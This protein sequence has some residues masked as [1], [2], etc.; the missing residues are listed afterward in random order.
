MTHNKQKLMTKRESQTKFIFYIYFIRHKFQNFCLFCVLLIS[1]RPKVI[2]ISVCFVTMQPRN[3]KLKLVKIVKEIYL[4]KLR[5]T[6]IERSDFSSNFF[7]PTKHTY[8]TQRD[9]LKITFFTKK[10][11][12]KN[13]T[14]PICYLFFQ[15]KN[16]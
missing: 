11:F 12:P 16:D 7:D 8:M 10:G 14:L 6:R 13:E 9:N 15:F 2:I 1:V 3:T 5:V 4:F